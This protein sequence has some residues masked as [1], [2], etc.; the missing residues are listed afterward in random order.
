V[1]DPR[2]VGWDLLALD[3]V[4]ALAASGATGLLLGLVFFWGLWVTVKRLG[5]G[6][7]AALWMLGGFALRFGVLLAGFYLLARHAGWQ[8]VVSAA[9]GFTLS[10]AFVVNRLRP[11]RVNKESGA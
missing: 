3:G 6:R 8:H 9:L 7:S 4:L 5:R 11:D 2:F 1:S 10:R